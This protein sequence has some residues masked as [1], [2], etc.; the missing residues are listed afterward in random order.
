MRQCNTDG[1][2]K[3]K[4]R[5]AADE[6]LILGVLYDRI[7]ELSVGIGRAA[8]RSEQVV[9]GLVCRAGDCLPSTRYPPRCFI[10]QFPGLIADIMNL[11]SCCIGKTAV[12]LPGRV[13]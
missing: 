3:G 1:R 4:G 9:R 8:A 5:C 2:P 13:N 10:E 11:A 7:V 12:R 6:R